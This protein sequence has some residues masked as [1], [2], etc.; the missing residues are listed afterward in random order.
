MAQAP[1]LSA[2]A[3]L[4]LALFAFDGCL[5]EP[6]GPDNPAFST[7]TPRPDG[8]GVE[9]EVV[10]L[11]V[12]QSTA[13]QCA[14]AGKASCFETLP[15]VFASAWVKHP[16]RTFLID[17]TLRKN[18]EEDLK[19][20]ALPQRLALSAKR[21]QDLLEALKPLGPLPE[22]VLVTHG[23]WDHSS[24]LRDLGGVVAVLGPGEAE[25]VR[26]QAGQKPPAVMADH[27][28][29]SRLQSF[30]WDGPPYENFPGSHDWFKDGSVVFVPLPGHTPGSYGIF[31]NHVAGKRLLFVGDAAWGL[32][33]ISLPSH[34]LGA[35]SRF[36]DFDLAQLSE[37]L[38]R[39]HH[40]QQRDPELIIVPAHD[41]RAFARVRAL[42]HRQP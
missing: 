28:E 1:C 17:A 8:G 25:F 7:F 37:T 12:S 23:H 35:L 15:L 10:P 16:S 21:Q 34:K 20:F 40:L 32:E 2:A 38:W 29:G 3:V 41:G 5:T 11:V 14:V 4:S 6:L 36:V 31:L 22:V 33:A 19:R 42:T 30:P 13:P 24:G 39:L 27:F 26:Q 9:L 18:A